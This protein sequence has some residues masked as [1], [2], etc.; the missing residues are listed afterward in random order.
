MTDNRIEELLF[1][2]I[3]SIS[4]LNANMKSALEKIASHEARIT[5]LEHNKTSLKDT[6]IQW[7]VKGLVAATLTVASLTGAGGL[8]IKLFGLFG[9]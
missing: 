7:L 8:I 9:S 3:E 6:A 2:F 5:V 1:R 4:E